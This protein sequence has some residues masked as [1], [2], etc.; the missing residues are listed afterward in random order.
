MKL[1][2]IL[3]DLMKRKGLGLI[4]LSKASKVP[5]QTLHNWLSGAEHR[6]VDQ[7][8]A[9]ADV[10]GLTIE[11][12]CY[13]SKTQKSKHAPLDEYENEINAGVFEVVLRRVGKR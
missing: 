7:L 2:A 1:S 11:E 10:F 4:E 12:L 5:K 13:G 3:K 6:S 8:K 9:V